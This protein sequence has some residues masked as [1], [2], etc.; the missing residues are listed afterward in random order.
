L[1]LLPAGRRVRTRGIQVHGNAVNQARSGQRTAVNLGGVDV[2]DVERG[3]VLAKSGR[4][5]PTQIIDTEITMLSGAPRSIKTRSRVRLHTGSAEVLARVR[6]LNNEGEIAPGASDFAQLRLETP[7]VV[8]HGDRFI[9]RSYSPAETVA[10]GLVLDPFALKHRGRELAKTSDRLRSLKQADA[11]GRF[12]AFVEA[13]GDL[14]L[15]PEDLA[16][17][18]GWNDDVLV[19]VAARAKESGTIIEGNGFYLSKEAI[20]RLSSLAIG[21]IK[22]HHQRE[23]LARGLA[24]ETL[25][26]RLF[27]HTPVEVFRFIITRLESGG[28]LS[29]EKDLVRATEHTLDLSSSDKHLRDQIVGVY[30]RAGLE[31]PSLDQALQQAGVAAPQRNHARKLLQLLLNEGTLVRVHG[32]TFFHAD[33]LKKLKQ[34]LQQYAAEHEPDR[35]IDVP[36]FKEL[37]GI[38]R[39]YAIPLLEYFDRERVTQRAGD[40]RIILK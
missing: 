27:A 37:A 28:L 22:K 26:E 13:S 38:S 20:Q 11:V 17:R 35:L 16:A 36:T 6:V 15:E 29:S 23:P 24:R 3:M 21:E 19:R 2:T 34:T 30:E 18:F 39:K 7:V 1:E 5:R 33:A 9:I 32:E 12:T 4:L 8:L 14:G 10:G 40:K 25:R 31:A